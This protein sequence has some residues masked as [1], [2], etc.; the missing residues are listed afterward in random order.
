MN[1][2]TP[3]VTFLIA[4][5]ARSGTTLLQRLACELPDVWV[6]PE[7]HLWSVLLSPGFAATWPLDRTEAARLLDAAAKRSGPALG[8]LDPDR[9]LDGMDEPVRPWLLFERLVHELAPAGRDILGEKTPNHL[10]AAGPLLREHRDLRLVVTVRDPRDVHASLLDVPWGGDDVVR[11][12]WRWRLRYGHVAEL[13]TAFGPQRVLTVRLEDVVADLDGARRRLAGFLGVDHG[14]V[15]LP[16]DGH[17]LFGD[18]EPWKHQAVGAADPAR[19]ARWR[20]RLDPEVATTVW[21]IT[22]DIAASWGYVPE[23]CDTPADTP[24][25]T[26]GSVAMSELRLHTLALHQPRD[27]FR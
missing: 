18:A 21:R 3:R 23:G 11:N 6:P 17:G 7:T 24:K 5:M 16:A 27:W 22:A 8:A 10:L 2:T 9:L 13:A 14:V 26:E 25:N 4:G 20:E 15:P 1:A 19:A 12:A